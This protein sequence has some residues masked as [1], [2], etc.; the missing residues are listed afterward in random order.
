MRE[1]NEIEVMTGF[2]LSE[3]MTKIDIEGEEFECKEMTILGEDDVILE[4]VDVSPDTT[5]ETAQENTGFV[6]GYSKWLF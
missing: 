6:I 5:E 4:V 1:K 2:L 3:V